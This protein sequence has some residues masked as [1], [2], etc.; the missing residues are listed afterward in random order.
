MT[1]QVTL[2]LSDRLYE[3]VRNLAQR[4]QS[5][6]AEAIIEHLEE[7]LSPDKSPQQ[8]DVCRTERIEA[9][10]CEEAAYITLHPQLKTT[11]FGLYVAIYQGKL[12]DEDK[13]LGSMIE[14]VRSQLP[15][16]VVWM[17][18]VKDEPL[19][20]IVKRGNRLLRNSG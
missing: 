4:R 11:H 7:T 3:R 10:A 9:L 19:Q 2:T 5:A 12:I 6:L 15:D 14:R 8:I 20:T 16:Q 13:V 17:T 1:A 18:Q